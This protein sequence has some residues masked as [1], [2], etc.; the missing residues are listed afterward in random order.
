MT[1]LHVV[2]YPDF[3][4][5]DVFG[6]VEVLSR[7][8]DADIHYVSLSGGIVTNHQSIRIETGPFSAM[9]PGGWLLIPGGWGSRTVIDDDGFLRTL[10]EAME[11]A[12]RVLCVCT[13]S[14]LAAS[15]GLL[16][17]RHAATNHAA[18]D[19]VQSRAPAVH[20]DRA[21]RWTAD[22]KFYTSAGV[23]AGIDMALGFVR[24]HFGK[25]AADA[26]CRRMEYRGSF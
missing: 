4:A 6:P 8:P 17:G 15:T 16:D 26:I 9:R 7:L 3:T 19:W 22:G 25:D 18:F 12:A 11:Q 14:A 23:S 1:P 10:R 21:A 24:D 5:L 20:W 2:L 13:V